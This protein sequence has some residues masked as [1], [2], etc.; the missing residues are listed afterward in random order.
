M[1][2][3]LIN[4]IFQT[5]SISA[6]NINSKFWIFFGRYFKKK[7]K[8]S[9]RILW[10]DLH[11]SKKF[12]SILVIKDGIII[13][14]NDLHLLKALSPIESIED[15]FW[16]EIFFNDEHWTKELTPIE[17]TKEKNW[18]LHQLW[19]SIKII[20]SKRCYKWWNRKQYLIFTSMKT[21][22]VLMTSFCKKYFL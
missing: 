21:I 14:S 6:F 2:I 11:P 17:D 8:I 19:T 20:Y 15:G 12:R 5:F 3:I 7:L 4:R 16:K 13:F 18:Y 9:L 22:F 10:N 1:N